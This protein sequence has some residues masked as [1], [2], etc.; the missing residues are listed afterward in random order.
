MKKIDK[1]FIISINLQMTTGNQSQK[2][3]FIFENEIREKIF[4]LSLIHI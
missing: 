3:G 1:F 4:D 2:H